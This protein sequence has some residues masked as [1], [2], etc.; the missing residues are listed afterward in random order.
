LTASG[1]TVAN[2][3]CNGGNDGSV[4]VTP[5]GG[6]IPYTYNW[7]SSPLQTTS[8]ATGLTAGTYTVTVTDAHSCTAISSATITQPTMLTASARTDKR[9]AWNDC[10]DRCVRELPGVVTLTCTYSCRQSPLQTMS[11]VMV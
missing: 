7:S 1:S 6:T 3:Q 11:T 4:T 10:D 5:G 9:R 2:V 8:T